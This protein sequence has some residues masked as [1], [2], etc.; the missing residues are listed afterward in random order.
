MV[1]AVGCSNTLAIRRLADLQ[2]AKISSDVDPTD[3]S[4]DVS[5]AD[6]SI[7]W[8]PPG[9][10]DDGRIG[11]AVK[12]HHEQGGP[13]E[14]KLCGH[15]RCCLIAQGELFPRIQASIKVVTE[16]LFPNDDDLVLEPE[17][18]ESGAM[19]FLPGGQGEVREVL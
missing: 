8:S 12:K 18:K 15:D 5:I 16:G 2:R 6:E 1:G 4:H 3:D 7:E 17:I 10:D 9:A 13:A 14:S 11:P 19:V